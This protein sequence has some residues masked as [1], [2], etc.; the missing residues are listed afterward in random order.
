MEESK[1]NNSFASADPNVTFK[2]LEKD[3]SR[4]VEFLQQ[5]RHGFAEILNQVLMK[6][7]CILKEI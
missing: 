2:K 3:Y 7:F 5:V 6:N 1:E 4:C